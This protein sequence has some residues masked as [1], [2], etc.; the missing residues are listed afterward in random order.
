MGPIVLALA[1][2]WSQPGNA[3]PHWCENILVPGSL[4]KVLT[5]LLTHLPEQPV[6]YHLRARYRVLTPSD[7]NDLN[8]MAGRFKF[9]NVEM[10]LERTSA[11]TSLL[12]VDFRI[13]GLGRDLAIVLPEMVENETVKKAKDWRMVRLQEA[14]LEPAVFASPLEPL[15]LE[16]LL[17]R[18]LSSFEF[19]VRAL[20]A[21]ND[22]NIITMGQLVQKTPEELLRVPHFGRRSLNE[23][24]G[25]L[26]GLGVGLGMRPPLITP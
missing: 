21:L 5:T 12:L 13:V 1:I 2:L 4:R 24:E 6:A 7:W 9:K 11:N 10:A 3:A 15:V 14:E 20:T 16:E 18:P 25:L 8:A 19:S 22:E 23:V 26:Q 17:K